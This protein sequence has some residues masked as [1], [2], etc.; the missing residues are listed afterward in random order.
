MYQGDLENIPD[1]ES[2]GNIEIV[3]KQK[4]TTNH[5]M[6]IIKMRIIQMMTIMPAKVTHMT[7]I[8]S[9]MIMVMWTLKQAQECK[10][11]NAKHI[12]LH[13]NRGDVDNN[14]T[15]KDDQGDKGS[16]IVEN[17]NN[18]IMTQ[19]YGQWSGHYNL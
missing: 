3:F 15:E 16:I 11:R 10:H 9:W 12:V 2:E 18:V 19:K 8:K 1:E 14:N 7:K 6:M 5:H 13:S 4:I 17:T